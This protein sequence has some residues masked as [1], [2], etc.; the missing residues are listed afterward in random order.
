MG[1]KS[2]GQL[3]VRVDGVRLQTIKPPHRRLSQAGREDLEHQRLV[4]RMDSHPLFELAHMLYWV[5]STVVNG[6]GWLL[7][8]SMEYGPFYVVRERRLGELI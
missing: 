3:L 8:P 4:P 5:C 6:E 7:E 2:L 1:A